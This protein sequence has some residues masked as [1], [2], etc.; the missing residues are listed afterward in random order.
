MAAAEDW[1]PSYGGHRICK[2]QHQIPEGTRGRSE[3]Y[4]ELSKQTA[5]QVQNSRGK[6]GFT[7]LLNRMAEAE[8]QKAQSEW[9]Q[10]SWMEGLT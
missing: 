6:P 5:R 7:C 4:E 8:G 9:G 1:A 3:P 10:N 2:P